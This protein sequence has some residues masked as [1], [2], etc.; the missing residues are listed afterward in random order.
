MQMRTMGLWRFTP[1]ATVRAD[2]IL[3]MINSLG[4]PKGLLAVEKEISLLPHC[5]GAARGRR[6]DLIC[7]APGIHRG[8]SLYPLLLIE[9]K[10]VP[11]TEAA[12]RQLV[13]YNA[14][15]Q[16]P[17]FCLVNNSERRLFWGQGGIDS[18]SFLPFLPSFQELV[19]RCHSLKI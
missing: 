4:Y 3:H 2:L 1:E 5:K 17:F 11:L 14:A 9:C 19:E 7:F 6:A 12:F 10:A 16:A 18:S 13:G 15:V 8:F